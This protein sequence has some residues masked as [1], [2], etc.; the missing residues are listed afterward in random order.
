MDRARSGYYEMHDV[1]VHETF[2]AAIA[3]FCTWK[4]LREEDWV[5]WGVRKEATGHEL[6]KSELDTVYIDV[7]PRNA[8]N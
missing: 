4:G 8:N 2:G 6:G 5:F 7:F 1:S 3:R